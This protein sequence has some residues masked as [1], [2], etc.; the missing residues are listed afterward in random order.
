MICF[1][2][3][4]KFDKAPYHNQC[5]MT[6]IRIAHPSSFRRL[7]FCT[8]N[9]SNHLE[10]HL[11]CTVRLYLLTF[12]LITTILFSLL[13][14]NTNSFALPTSSHSPPFDSRF[15]SEALIRRIFRLSLRITTISTSGLLLP[16]SRPFRATYEILAGYPKGLSPKPLRELG[17]SG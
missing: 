7:Y 13:V 14:P 15:P 2:E 6:R 16:T 11:D 5:D 17:R 8:E 4:R 3:T 12:T 1:E 10:I 9:S